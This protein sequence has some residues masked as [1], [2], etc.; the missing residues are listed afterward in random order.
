MDTEEYEKKVREMLSDEKTYSK[1]NSDP[2]P[3][4]RKKLVAILDRLKS[5]KKINIK[6]TPIPGPDPIQR[7][8]KHSKNVLHT[9]NP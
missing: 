8:P 3:K 9:K 5:E 2:T 6:T 1:L 7:K 4:Y